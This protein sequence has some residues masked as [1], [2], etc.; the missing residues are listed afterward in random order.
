MKPRINKVAAGQRISHI[1]QMWFIDEPLYFSTYCTHQPTPNANMPIAMRVGEGRLEYNPDIVDSLTD[2]QLEAH[3]KLE[4]LRVMLQHPYQRLPYN[5][6]SRLL[7]IASNLAIHMNSETDEFPFDLVP[8]EICAR[9]PR[10]LSFEDYYY[11][12][13]E[14]AENGDLD[15]SSADGE[16]NPFFDSVFISALWQEDDLMA[17]AIKEVVQN[18]IGNNACGNIPGGLIDKIKAAIVPKFDLSAVLRGFKSTILS[19]RRELTRM[20]PSRRYGFMQMGVRRPYTTSLLVAVDVSGS[21]SNHM[22]SVILGHINRLFKQGIERIDILQFDCELKLPVLP[23]DKCQAS[24]D[25]VG[26]GGTDFQPVADLYA[27]SAYDG[28]IICTDGCAPNPVVEKPTPPVIWL[29][30]KDAVN[31]MLPSVK[32]GWTREP[33]TK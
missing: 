7:G 26:R 4:L 2:I 18:A 16:S 8:D 3:I 27:E 30:F 6:D 24:L 1:V 14:M 9:M 12:L 20:R 31:P 19:Q 11:L 32:R 5:S 25:I 22:L 10:G 29:E 21:V 33:L 28:L 17:Q 13:Q 15:M 23:I